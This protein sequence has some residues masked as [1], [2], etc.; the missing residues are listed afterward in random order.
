MKKIL[1]VLT[2]LVVLAGLFTSCEKPE[3]TEEKDNVQLLIS[4]PEMVV[5]GEAFSVKIETNSEQTKSVELFIDGASQGVEFSIPYEYTIIPKDW[6]TG[7]HKLVAQ[8][9]LQDGEIITST[10]KEITFIVKLGDTY[11]GGVVIQISDNGVHGVIASKK[12]ITEES[13]GNSGR[14]HYGAINEEY[15]AYSMDDG[16]ANTLKF[17][18][19]LNFNYAAP[20]CLQLELNG[21]DDWYLP[22]YNQLLLFENFR[23]ALNIPERGGNTYWSSTGH[24]DPEK[25]YAVSF[26][27]SIGNPCSVTQSFYVRP[28]RN[29]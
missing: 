4:A 10:I 1:Y 7:I 14:Y 2:S 18:G 5:N 11:Q 15:Q 25:A 17:E 16:L 22:A 27:G 28:C 20:A 24:Q 19:K 12:D 8:G 29:F 23:E 21:F 13:I 26:G 6:N 9:R 3:K